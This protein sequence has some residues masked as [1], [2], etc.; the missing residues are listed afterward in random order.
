MEKFLFKEKRVY[1]LYVEYVYIFSECMF[2]MD[3][4]FDFYVVEQI[5]MYEF[6]FVNKIFSFFFSKQMNYLFKI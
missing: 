3:V 6:N 4:Q 1:E 5:E 2:I